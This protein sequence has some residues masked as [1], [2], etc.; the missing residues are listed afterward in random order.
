[1]FGPRLDERP[2]RVGAHVQTAL[3]RRGAQV[4]QGVAERVAGGPLGLGDRE[5]EEVPHAVPGGEPVVLPVGEA[6]VRGVRG[7]RAGEV[8]DGAED[9]LAATALVGE[10]SLRDEPLHAEP[11]LLVGHAEEAGHRVELTGVHGAVL[12]DEGVDEG[13]GRDVD[14]AGI[15]GGAGAGVGAG[16]GV[17]VGVGVGVGL[18]HRVSWPGDASAA[19]TGRCMV[20]T[21]A[22]P[23]SPRRYGV[24]SVWTAMKPCRS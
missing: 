20:V 6:D 17:G 16:T 2:D 13:A 21:A 18:G 12:A 7:E 14:G 1:M 9:R 15:A 23:M 5:G 8:G 22:K 11:H 19:V 24:R 3:E 10:P 4:Q